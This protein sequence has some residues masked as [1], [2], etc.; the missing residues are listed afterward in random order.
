MAFIERWQ[1][2]SSMS[3]VSLCIV[4]VSLSLLRPLR[5]VD[6]NWFSD[7]AIKAITSNKIHSHVQAISILL[8]NFVTLVN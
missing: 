1:F 2:N 8:V 6:L 3:S 4:E 5:C 7:R